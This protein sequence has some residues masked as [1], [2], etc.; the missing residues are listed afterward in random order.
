MEKKHKQIAL[1]LV[2]ALAVSGLSYYFLVVKPK[3]AD[4]APPVL[5]NPAPGTNINN[6]FH[7]GSGGSTTVVISPAI[8]KTAYAKFAGAKV[9]NNDMSVYKTCA[10]VGEWVGTITATA[11]KGNAPYYQIEG[12]RWVPQVSVTYS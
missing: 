11:T 7:Q 10:T 8:G 9:F 2:I 3:Q 12:I 4:S 5:D 1:V 6:I